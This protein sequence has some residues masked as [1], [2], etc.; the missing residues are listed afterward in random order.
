MIFTGSL[1]WWWWWWWESWGFTAYLETTHGVSIRQKLSSHANKKQK[2]SC[3]EKKLK[4][5]YYTLKRRIKK[6][7]FNLTKVAII[8][9]KI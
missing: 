7:L 2:K 8:L 4:I 3:P 1:V 5:H 9:G 6:I